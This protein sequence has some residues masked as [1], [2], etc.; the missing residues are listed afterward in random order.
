MEKTE[1][2]TIKEKVLKI[3]SECFDFILGLTLGLSLYHF[4]IV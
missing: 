4:S 2:E 3:M 1:F